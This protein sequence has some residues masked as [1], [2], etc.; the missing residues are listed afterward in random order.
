MNEGN[1]QLERWS[2]W[3]RKGSERERE[4][5]SHNLLMIVRGMK[6]TDKNAEYFTH[7]QILRFHSKMI[8]FKV[9]YFFNICYGVRLGKDLSWLGYDCIKTKTLGQG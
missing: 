3:R 4:R 6:K 2:R 8:F 5:E 1:M 7:L 9:F